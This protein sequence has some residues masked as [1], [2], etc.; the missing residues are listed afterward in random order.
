MY[1]EAVIERV[2]R[3]TWRLR[4]REVRDA[5]GDRDQAS[6]EMHLGTKRSSELT[7]A[8]IHLEAVIE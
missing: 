2:W 3:C 1:L 4:W 6:L 8:E 7:D 5:L